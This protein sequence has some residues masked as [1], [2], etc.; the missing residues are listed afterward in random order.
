MAQDSDQ[1]DTVLYDIARQAQKKA[2]RAR[3]Q[4]MKR[5]AKSTQQPHLDHDIW[6]DKAQSPMRVSPKQQRGM[7]GEDQAAQ[8]LRDQGLLVLARNIH[9][10][11]GEIDLI[12]TDCV[13]LIFVEVRL[14]GSAQ[15]G[16]A[17][18]SVTHA[19]QRR[20]I[21]T[22]QFFLPRL[23]ARYF[24]GKLPPCRFDVISIDDPNLHWIKHA[25]DHTVD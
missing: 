14:R 22:A 12:A 10:R 3:K 6:N 13:S 2:V 21:R 20:L 16:G 18:A 19:K 9:C 7:Q 1:H 11:A 4:K 17:A 23:R 8:Y 24:A 15:Y 25:F 5:V